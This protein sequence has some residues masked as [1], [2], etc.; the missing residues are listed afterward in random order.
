MVFEKKVSL[1]VMLCNLIEKKA[2]KCHYYWSK[3]EKIKN[4]K[5]QITSEKQINENYIIRDFDCTC[6]KTNEVRKIK[7]L[8]FTGWPD[9]GVPE[10]EKVF[11]TFQEMIAEVE[12]LILESP[13]VVHCS[14]GVGRTGTFISMY[15]I[16]HIFSQK[17]L[18]EDVAFNFNIWNLV[19][20]LK[21]HRIM[22][23]ENILQYKFIYSY[24]GKYLFNIL[25]K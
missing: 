23:V 9:H 22:S 19:R 24:V 13:V 1:I 21:E 20:K 12:K 25:K 4:F 14:A 17:M 6:T 8:H 15:N 18:G 3:D 16:H 10:I 7:Q 5:L 11:D 2:S